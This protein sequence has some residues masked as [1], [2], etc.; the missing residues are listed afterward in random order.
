[1]KF[2]QQTIR[3][4]K[5]LDRRAM[6]QTEKK[7]AAVLQD[8]EAF[9]HLRDILISYAGIVGRDELELPKKC[10]VIA[11]A[12]HGV[13]EM[14][15]SAY[16]PETTVQMT[17][18][19]LIS[20][21]AVA[22]ALSNFS[23]ARM[24][25]VDMGIAAP[26]D[27]VPGLVDKKIAFGTKNCAK[28]PAMTREE[29][30]RS[31]R[32]GIEIAELYAAKGYSCFLPGEMGIANTTSSA[33]IAATL[34]GLS[35]EQATGRGTNISDER[36]RVKIEVVRAALAA[37]R[38]DPGDGLDVLAKIGGFELG[39]IA[40]LILG[41]AAN[42]SFVVLDGFNTGAAALIAAALCPLAKQY[43]MGSHL[44]AE[45]AHKK[46]LETLGI[47]PYMDMQF[48]LGE[49]TGSSI[50]VNLLDAIVR[51]YAQDADAI[52]PAVKRPPEQIVDPGEEALAALIAK[53]KPP[54]AGCMEQCQFYID[55]LTKP[56][57]SLGA[58]EQ[59]AVKIAGI[60]AR[61]KPGM[62]KKSILG[63]LPSSFPSPKE[64]IWSR[65]F[66]AHAQAALPIVELAA[67]GGAEKQIRSAIFAGAR[68]ARAEIEAGR[69]L[70]GLRALNPQEE[71]AAAELLSACAAG[72]PLDPLQAL[73]ARQSLELAAMTG[74]ILS[75]AANRAAVVLD[76]FPT[77]VAALLAVKL[78]PRALD[79]LILPGKSPDRTRGALYDMLPLP[80]YL[81]LNMSAGGGAASAL[82]MK[83]VDAS[84][85]MLNDMKTFAQAAVAVADD[86]PGAQ[87]Q[88][89]R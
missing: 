68:L 63:F 87:R 40:G 83:L 85:H 62:M 72:G 56:I 22:N 2:L 24:V 33:A 44:A 76:D 25:V 31:I 41:A 61:A 9:G 13:A 32:A 80:A 52:A 4:I 14:K 55:N 88:K 47:R 70:L 66:A 84:L 49:A 74:A 18:N 30:L 8:A 3:R 21:G 37:N 35:P 71:K 1:M 12:D 19:Y 53:I 46:I 60:T 7:L 27:G 17:K 79:Y 36:L 39:C 69:R 75:A 42:R 45:P 86:G 43:L 77:Q 34:C 38:P 58:L 28:G 82:G 26:M 10:T 78:A 59:L 64:R 5:P 67:G 89:N 48:R 23:G 51:A 16:P 20:K 73:I 11:C 50:A 65:A 57:H 6:R 29:A 15:I 54:D 81:N